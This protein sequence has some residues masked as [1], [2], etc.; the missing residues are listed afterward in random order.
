MAETTLDGKVVMM[1][2]AGRGMGR[3]MSIGLA[4]AGA[5]VAM[6][7]IDADVLNEAASLV[8]NAGGQGAALP[9]VADVTSADNAA[10]AVQKVL[11]RFGRIDVLVNDAVV[12]PERIGPNFFTDRTKF[13]DLD[14][15]LWRQML[16]VNIFGPQLMARTVVPH[17]LEQGW[18]RIVNITTS[19]DTMYLAG[20]G[21]YGP[22]KAALEAHTRIM[23]H[24]L[25]DTG[26]G[27][28]VLIPGGPV[29]TRMIPEASG[30]PREN[31]I[32][33]DVMV[34]P[35]IWLTSNDSDGVSGMRFIAALWDPKLDREARMEQAGAP[36][37]WSQIESR[38]I[39]PDD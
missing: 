36:L 30:I 18:G 22:T 27:V 13:W 37:A 4:G 9:V 17:M 26:V 14:D 21:A 25:E 11:D 32:Q 23:A 12:G 38:S 8:E 3:E 6:I 7:D 2:G 5:K 1:T 10:T 33:P 35:I 24:D 20:A 39:Y 15:G 29:N 34:R 28:N 31:L 19:L 16:N